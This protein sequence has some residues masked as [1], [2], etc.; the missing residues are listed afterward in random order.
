MEVDEDSRGYDQEADDLERP[1]FDIEAHEN[2]RGHD[3]EAAADN[4]EY[5]LPDVATEDNGGQDNQEDLDYPEYPEEEEIPEHLPGMHEYADMDPEG[6]IRVYHEGLDGRPCDENGLDLPPGTPP[7]LPPPRRSDDWT[8]YSSRVEYET[9]HLLYTV[10]QMPAKNIDWL[11]SLWRTTLLKYGED[12]P[13]TNHKDL[14]RTIDSTLLGDVKWESFELKY[15]GNVP[16]HDVPS[17]MNAVIRCM[18]S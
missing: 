11:L 4:L 6:L 5:P 15:S 18:V 10:D 7:T 17:W 16:D 14:Y 13:F 3:Q 12:G 9:A 2:A 1:A 8:P